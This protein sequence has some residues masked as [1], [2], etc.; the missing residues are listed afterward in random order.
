MRKI[1]N[2]ICI[3]LI[4]AFAV[5]LALGWN[6]F[7]EEVPT[8]FDLSGLA[9]SFGP[10]N[11]LL[12]DLAVMAGLFLLLAI[13]ESFPGIWNIPVEVTEDNKEAIL[14]IFYTMFAVI[15]I[16]VVLICAYS[17]FMCIYYPGFSSAPM[18]L[19]AGVIVITILASTF[20]VFKFR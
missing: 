11:T 2:I 12:R 6:G 4:A 13:V 14:R 8:H 9:D 17:T 7:P 3:V 10:K 18:M 16:S 19:L 15:K 5:F 20:L 1:S